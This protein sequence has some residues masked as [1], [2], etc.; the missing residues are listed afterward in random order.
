MI[1]DQSGREPCSG[2]PG[3]LEVAGAVEGEGE[4]EVA[5]GRPQHS[6]QR[7]LAR[8]ADGGEGRGD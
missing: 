2:V 5:G 4:E 6:L 7:V 8:R 1:E 3:V